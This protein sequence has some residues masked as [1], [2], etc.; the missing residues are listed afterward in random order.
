MPPDADTRGVPRARRRRVVGGLA[1][2]A[3]AG[4]L[5][6]AG[7]ALWVRHATDGRLYSSADVAAVPA[8][9]VTMVLGAGVDA[10]GR[11]S[12]FLAARLDL[13]LDLYRR[14]LTQ[15]ILVSGAN[16][17]HDY[18]EP[19]AMRDYLI[20]RGVPAERIVADFAGLDTYD[21]CA[22][23]Q[24]IFGVDRLLVVSQSYH[25][26]RALAICRELG[27]DALGVGDETARQYASV[28]RDGQ[29]REYGANV[30][31]VWDVTSR[32]DPIL[33]P[34]ESGVL[35]ALAHA[36]ARPT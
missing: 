20:A 1:A 32:R 2:V 28:W 4:A 33:G 11:P 23:A 7:P 9:P 27:L 10:P 30:K 14:G 19:T 18:D 31:A 22:R 26:P 24:R 8:T 6:I 36:G 16:P 35:D 13:A 17:S 34:R 15:V 5:G 29:I 25:L 12:R 3:L 21:S